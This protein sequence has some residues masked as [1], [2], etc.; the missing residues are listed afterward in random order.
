MGL[1]N[2]TAARR[3]LFK[4]AI[5]GDCWEYRGGQHHKNGYRK[6]WYDGHMIWAHRFAYEQWKGILAN[7]EQVHHVCFHGWCVKPTHLIAVPKQEH[8]NGYR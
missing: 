8:T 4:V 3:F 1:R 2:I 6:F 7:D 5:R